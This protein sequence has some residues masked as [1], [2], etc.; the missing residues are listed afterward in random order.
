MVITPFVR[1]LLGLDWDALDRTLTVKP[2]VPA[3][4][5]SVKVHNVPLGP[6]LVEVEISRH[7]GELRIQS[8]SAQPEQFCLRSGQPG[9][10]PCSATPA[11]V[12]ELALPVRPVEVYVSPE[13][14]EPGSRTHGLKII[15]ERYDN[16]SA[17]FTFSGPGDAHYRLPLRRNRPGVTVEGATTSQA[18][19]LLTIPPGPGYQ[20]Q[21]VTFRW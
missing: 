18:E 12:H 16:R 19:L 7:N 4:W 3:H 11:R 15:E 6:L 9:A 20:T 13:L 10:P 2:Q 17:S 8:T 21:T 14:P 1:G 5:N